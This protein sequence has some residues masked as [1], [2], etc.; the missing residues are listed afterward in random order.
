[1][2]FDTAAARK[3]RGAFFTPPELAEFLCRWAIRD[4]KDRVFEPSCGDAVFLQAS[5]DHL[6]ELGRHRL[7]DGQL[8]GL[9]IHAPSI[10]QARTR[11][12]SR[13]F[14]A[15]LH[16]GD[17][18]AHEL[19]ADRDVVVGNPPFVRYQ[20][21]AGTDRARAQRVAFAAGVPLS[22]LASSW[23]AFTIHAAGMLAPGGRLGLV[24]P[25]ELLTTNYA[26]EVRAWLL[27]RFGSVRLIMFT[28][29]VFPEVQ[30]EVVLLLAEGQGPTTHFELYETDNVGTL[31]DPADLPWSL[32]NIAPQDKWIGALVDQRAQT[33]HAKLLAGEAFTVLDD[34]GKTSLGSVT[35]NNS[36]FT[37][38]PD[39]VETHK[40]PACD[41]VRISP[42]GSR[43]LRDL[44]FTTRRWER[45]SE[46]GQATWL[47]RPT[48]SPSPAS[49][50]RIAEG[51][52]DGID[53]A[54]KCRVRSTW[55][56]VP[57]S[58]P[59]DLFVTYMNADTPRLSSNRAR[60]RALNSVHGLTLRS[61]LRTV[62]RSLLALGSL[63]TVTLL[64]AELVGRAY[65]GGMLK[66]E[67][68]EAARLPM[69]TPDRLVELTSAL[70]HIQ[71]QVATRLRNKDL[72]GAVHLVD[73]VVL[74]GLVTNEQLGCLRDAHDQLQARR[75]QR[76]SS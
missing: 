70:R 72:L 73:D 69:P 35:G 15:T 10:E 53:L 26:A 63:N 30:E 61:E 62:G 64:G 7:D 20:D 17:F 50:H 19:P 3:A 18:F 45:L 29:R 66:V 39:E 67:P 31:T 41:R 38:T 60:V 71:P 68:T 23:A 48:D 74:D 75:R 43:H 14:D 51:E 11:L 76:S 32:S 9:D 22:G 6:V 13:G 25:A 5:A 57:L 46:Q 28:D 55:W 42:P 56:Q 52:H 4:T 65:G 36:W 1:M 49:R 16:V 44:S 27:R 33:L 24:L 58:P 54:Y 2:T 59:P 21:F 12:A 8:A 40:I 34:W 47:F 37:L